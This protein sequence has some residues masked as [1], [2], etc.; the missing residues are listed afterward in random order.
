MNLSN[1]SRTVSTLVM[2]A[3]QKSGGAEGCPLSPT[4]PRPWRI[5]RN[6]CAI[7]T[8]LIPPLE[9]FNHPTSEITTPEPNTESHHG[10][11]R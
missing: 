4:S 11:G 6:P 10:S 5:Q 8:K 7:L 1:N 3:P 2:E 9:K